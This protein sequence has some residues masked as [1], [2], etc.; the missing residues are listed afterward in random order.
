MLFDEPLKKMLFARRREAIDAGRRE[1][2]LAEMIETADRAIIEDDDKHTAASTKEIERALA[3]LIRHV[4]EH[5]AK[6][7]AA[8]RDCPYA[9]M[10][11]RLID[12][13]TLCEAA[14]EITTALKRIR[15]ANTAREECKSA[16]EY[17]HERAE[18]KR[19]ELLADIEA[20][21]RAA[22]KDLDAATAE[23]AAAD[24]AAAELMRKYG[25]KR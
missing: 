21:E 19:K 1:R 16:A 15:D 13:R 6:R 25:V 2:E 24:R 20:Y 12:G 7:N 17:Y 4:G 3:P 18:E 5:C 14:E 9:E 11:K 22:N 23:C 8:C 10:T